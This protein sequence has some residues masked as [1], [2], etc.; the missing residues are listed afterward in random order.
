MQQ[1]SQKI[2]S[3]KYC[4]KG[5]FPWK[6]RAPQFWP[7]PIQT[8][9]KVFC[10]KTKLSII[11]MLFLFRLRLETKKNILYCQHDIEN[12]TDQIL[13]F[14]LFDKHQ[15]T[16]GIFWFVILV[17]TF[18]VTGLCKHFFVPHDLID[19][20]NSYFPRIAFQMNLFLS[21]Y[22]TSFFQWK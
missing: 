21:L 1:P 19:R 5:H 18:Y 7:P 14:L 16:H 6:K 8:F 15:F 4:P 22:I 3:I 13:N 12:Y 20:I 2:G 17:S 11:W 9:L 10:I